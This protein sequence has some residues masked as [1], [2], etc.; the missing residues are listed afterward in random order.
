MHALTIEELMLLT[1]VELTCLLARMKGVLA[2]LPDDSEDR[3][4]ALT[5][6]RNIRHVLAR[7]QMM[8]DTG[9]R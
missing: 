9:P 8:P 4:A 2:E 1:R 6:L 7:R 3:E 5:N